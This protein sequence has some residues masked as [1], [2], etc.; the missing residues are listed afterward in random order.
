MPRIALIHALALSI[1]PINGEL[2]RAWPQAERMNLLDDRLSADLARSA[3]GLDAR[4]TRRFLE[5]PFDRNPVLQ[6]AA[7]NHLMTEEV[8]KPIRVLAVCPGPV[9]TGFF[10]ASGKPETRAMSRRLMLKPKRV[11]DDAIDALDKNRSLC[12]PG[13]LGQSV[14]AGLPR[15]AP[16]RW[17]AA[18]LADVFGQSMQPKRKS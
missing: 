4:M 1:A 13:G 5:Q 3:S 10:E 14:I 11:V 9:D 17:V 18:R 7:V 2:E 6:F 12:V 8:H 16:R 15:V